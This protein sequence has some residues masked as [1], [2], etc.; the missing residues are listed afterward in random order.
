MKLITNQ[1]QLRK[2]IIYY[3][4]CLRGLVLLTLFLLW[5]NSKLTDTQYYQLLYGVLPLS[6]M[7]ISF[8]VK[9]I[10][11][12]SRY[13]NPGEAVTQLH[14][15][16]SHTLPALF[17]VAEFVLIVFN[18]WFFDNNTDTLYWLVVGI[19][20]ISGIYAGYFLSGL[21]AKYPDKEAQSVK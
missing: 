2:T 3:I 7:Y 12:N 13:F 11:D 10:F 6:A 8:I 19:E 18:S 1:G 20:C 9:H 21:F 4:T 17:Y 14:I 5:K 15:K 16:I